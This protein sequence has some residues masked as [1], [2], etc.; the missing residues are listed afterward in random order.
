MNVVDIRKVLVFGVSGIRPHINKGL[1]IHFG[2]KSILSNLMNFDILL[3]FVGSFKFEYSVGRFQQQIMLDAPPEAIRREK[4]IRQALEIG[5]I[6]CFIGAHGDDYVFSR[7]INSYGIYFSNI[8]DGQ[9]FSD[10]KIRRSEFKP[11]LENVGSTSIKLRGESLDEI[12]CTT[13]NNDVV[14]FSKQIGKGLLLSLPCVMGSNVIQY[15]INLSE[16]LANGIISYY[17]KM[18]LEPPDWI[19][20]YKFTNEKDVSDKI[21]RI[22]SETITPLEKELGKYLKLKS[23]LWLGNKKLVEAVNDFL[24]RLGFETHIDEIFEEDLWILEKKERQIIIE[25]KGKNKNLTRQDISKLDEHREARQ[26]PNMTA[27]LVANTFMTVNSVDAKQEPFSRNVIEKAIN[28]NV[29]ITRTI[30]LCMIYDLK[31]N[32][33]ITTKNIMNI[34]KG[35]K[36]WLTVKNKKIII[37]S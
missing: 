20:C 6:V 16:T 36:G 37:S 21:E 28:T 11:F 19:S 15:I 14:G 34:M 8:G 23:I 2:D 12:L 32:S 10:L 26:V 4:E 3:Y 30:D 22:K 29:I 33:N 7:V 9:L 25:I 17:S 31:D 27:L 24:I 1:E 35:K 18:V 13:P 5:K